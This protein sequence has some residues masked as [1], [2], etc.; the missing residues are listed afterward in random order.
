MNQLPLP[1]SKE[2]L[3]LKMLARRG[4]LYGLEMV[5]ESGGRLKRGTIYITLSR[6]ENDKG[7]ITSRKEPAPPTAPG[8]PRRLYELSGHGARVLKALEAAEA[9]W[10]GAL[11]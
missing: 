1:S 11:A 5:K 3:I 7:Y 8:T 2:A 10:S 4:K 6:M 9:Q